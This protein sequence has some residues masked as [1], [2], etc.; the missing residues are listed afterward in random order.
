M[1]HGALASSVAPGGA[2]PFSIGCSA[3]RTRDPKPKVFVVPSAGQ[4]STDLFQFL[5]GGADGVDAADHF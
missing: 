4:G 3:A 5:D 1:R 2:K